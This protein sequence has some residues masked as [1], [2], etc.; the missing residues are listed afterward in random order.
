MTTQTQG[1]AV[2]LGGSVAGLFAARVLSDR[3]SEVVVVERDRLADEPVVRKGVPQGRHVHSLWTP[4]LTSLEALLPG[5][6]AELVADGAVEADA[7]DMRWWHAGAFRVRPKVG[8]GLLIQSRTLFEHHVRRRVRALARVTVRDETEV[9]GLS[10]G[11][12]RVTGVRLRAKRAGAVEEHLEAELIVD[13]TGRTSNGTAWLQ[14]LGAETPEETELAVDIAYVTR[15][16]K[17]RTNDLDAFRVL[18]V[19][20]IGPAERRIA[21]LFPIE[22]DRWCATLAGWLGD[23]PP[24][25]E[26]GW[27]EFARALPTPEFHEFVRGLEPV[28]EVSQFRFASNLRRHWERVRSPAERF[29]VLGDAL[30]SFNPAYGQGM[31]VAAFETRALAT[32]L[33]DGLDGLPARYFKLAARVVDQAWALSAGE[34]LRHPEVKGKRPFGSSFINAWVARLH[35]MSHHDE[36]VH[37]A[38]VRVFSL[39]QPLTTLLSPKLLW[40]ALVR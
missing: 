37:Q 14:A 34:D 23:H 21:V 22:G 38:M 12:T 18:L 8:V 15:Q 19:S 30:C 11:P 6:T 40:R 5:L 25:D 35:R 4:A 33:G 36:V 9:L 31:S 3:F 17:R 29:V 10:G 20:P 16:F 7:G 2:V 32:A 24:L 26:A 39:E 13:A 1:R 27:L 28:G